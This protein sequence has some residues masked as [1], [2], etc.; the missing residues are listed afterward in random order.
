MA[1]C[2]CTVGAKFHFIPLQEWYLQH[3]VFILKL[4]VCYS[5]LLELFLPASCSV[6]ACMCSSCSFADLSQPSSGGFWSDWD[7]GSRDMLSRWCWA[8]SSMCH[9]RSG[10]SH[11]SQLGRTHTQQSAVDTQSNASPCQYTTLVETLIRNFVQLI[12]QVVDSSNIVHSFEI[13]KHWHEYG[14]NFA[15]QSKLPMIH[16]YTQD[17]QWE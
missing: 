5:Y 4:G 2:L 11:N 6:T 8:P 9:D 3:F 10:S 15:Y 16:S 13:T 17:G 12:R 7:W 14:Q 1:E